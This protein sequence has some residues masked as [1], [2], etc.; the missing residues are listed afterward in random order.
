MR[1]RK[2]CVIS[3]LRYCVIATPLLGS[4]I[5]GLLL[6]GCDKGASD[7]QQQVSNRSYTVKRGDF[8][9]VF[10]S[11]GQLGAIKNHNL[12]FEGMRGG[13]DLKL[14][15]VTPALTIVKSNDVIFRISEEYFK[16]VETEYL[17]RLQTAKLNIAMAEKD[18]EMIQ[19]DNI[20][21]MKTA[22]DTLKTSV[23]AFNKYDKEDAPKKKR[24]LQLSV[25]AKINAMEKADTDL[26][27]ARKAH[28]DAYAMDEYKQMEAESKVN[29]AMI[30]VD[31]TKQDVDSA[32]QE[33]RIFKRYDHPEKL[34]SARETVKRNTL[35]VQR[36]IVKNETDLTKKVIEVESGK[37]D[38]EELTENLK[39]IQADMKK[40]DIRSPVNGT[41]YHG[42]PRDSSYYDE[43]RGVL[44]E[45]K[46]VWIGQTIAYIPD[47]SSFRVQTSIPEEFRSRVKVGQPVH[48]KTKAIPDLLLK[49]SIEEIAAAATSLRH[50]DAQG[51]KVYATKIS[52]DN[53]DP[54]VTSGMSVQL[55]IIVETI[56]EALYVPIEAVYTREGA[57]Y[58]KIETGK[59][60]FEEHKVKT[61]RFSAD[62]IELTEGVKEG[63]RV[64]LIR[65]TL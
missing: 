26:T 2:H 13:N 56:K 31:S 51:P 63:D 60:A 45:G 40:L 58:I 44:R 14:T 1:E 19:A 43:D 21:D 6:T 39:D 55:E 41:L 46:E 25:E 3:L 37:R 64:L 53:S 27:L 49:G 8:S 12:A 65:A 57:S 16:K 9:V 24:E 23:D 50:W 29:E 62:F 7:K 61:G 47:M 15:F 10:R 18:I 42:Q 36:G 20:N 32:F 11:D 30:K 4:V 38:L 5:C 52:T 59:D 33:L 35:A 54:R 17:Q 34:Q 22:L 28:A 48:I